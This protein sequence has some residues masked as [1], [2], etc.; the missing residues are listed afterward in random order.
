MAVS[1]TTRAQ[2]AAAPD[3]N[4]I[5][6]SLRSLR[7]ATML[8]DVV[9]LSYSV[10]LAWNLRSNIDV[11]TGPT[12]EAGGLGAISTDDWQASIDYLTTLELVPNPVTVEQVVDASLL[13]AR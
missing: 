1:A 13:P 7:A 11:W 6:R 8:A 4:R 9:V 10:L 3:R 5:H 12:Q 2:L